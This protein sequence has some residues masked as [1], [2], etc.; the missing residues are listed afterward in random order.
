MI[1]IIKIIASFLTPVTILIFG[2]LINRKLEKNK[3]DFI[4]EKEWQIHWS[5]RF[6]DT[7]YELNTNITLF[8]CALF[9]LQKASEKE[10]SDINEMISKYHKAI[11]VNEWEI[12]NYVQFAENNKE[13]VFDTLHEILTGLTEIL[14]NRQGNIEPIRQKQFDFNKAVRKAHAGILNIKTVHNNIYTK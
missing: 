1:E 11:T 14:N 10:Q 12:R 4:K 8:I 3:I 5:K 2:I 13:E 7:A 6:I 9:D